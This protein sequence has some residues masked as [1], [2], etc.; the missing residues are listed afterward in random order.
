MAYECIVGVRSEEGRGWWDT[1]ILVPPILSSGLQPCEARRDFI[2]D[3]SIQY[4]EK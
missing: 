4:L 3:Q 2:D 1:V